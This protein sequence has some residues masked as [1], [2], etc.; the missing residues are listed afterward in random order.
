M[1]VRFTPLALH[2]LD[3]AGDWIA[4]D[5][6]NRARS[7][8]KELR[9]KAIDIGQQPGIYPLA[10]FFGRREVRRRLHRGYLIFYDV[11]GG[12]VRILRVLHGARDYRNLI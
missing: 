10:P 4:R 6:P 1:S 2:D 12:G 3:T 9:Q 7:F 11:T 8:T 5:D